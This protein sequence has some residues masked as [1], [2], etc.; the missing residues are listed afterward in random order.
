MCM[1][2]YQSQQMRYP[3]TLIRC[4]VVSSGGDQA[5]SNCRPVLIYSL[6]P[7]KL[8]PTSKVQHIFA[9]GMNVETSD[10]TIPRT[11]SH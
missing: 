5:I 10:K 2:H 8:D 3:M 6:S 7:L 4:A 1:M 11:A 9:A